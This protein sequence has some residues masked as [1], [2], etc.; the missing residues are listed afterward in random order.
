MADKHEI[1]GI[2]LRAHH[3]QEVELSPWLPSERLYIYISNETNK[4]TRG[5]LELPQTQTTEAVSKQ[6][7]RNQLSAE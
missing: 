4:Q 6:I 2:P 5:N 1:E 3:R 7:E